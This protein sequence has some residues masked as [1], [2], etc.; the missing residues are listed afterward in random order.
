[1]GPVLPGPVEAATPP[2]L[3]SAWSV[4]DVR[5]QVLGQVISPSKALAASLA[6]VRPLTRMNSQMSRQ[7]R[8]T[9]ECSSAKKTHERSFTRMLPNVQLEVLLRPYTLAAKRTSESGTNEKWNVIY[10]YFTRRIR[11]VWFCHFNLI[12]C[13]C[14]PLF[15]PYLRSLC[16]SAASMRRKFRMDA[17]WGFNPKAWSLGI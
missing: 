17:S 4:V 12:M 16:L 14:Q 9:T 15:V 2:S 3:I 13:N 10:N 11:C 7:V 1:M 5:G 6:V 8:F